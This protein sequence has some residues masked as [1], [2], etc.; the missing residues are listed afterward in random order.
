MTI[1][2]SGGIPLSVLFSMALLV[3]SRFG[4]Y[5]ERENLESTSR[6]N[7]SWLGDCF[8]MDL[9]LVGIAECVDEHCVNITHIADYGMIN[10][11]TSCNKYVRY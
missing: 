10:N 1:V 2:N 8:V 7:T 5:Y 4:I 3:Y 11:A 6:Y 9:I